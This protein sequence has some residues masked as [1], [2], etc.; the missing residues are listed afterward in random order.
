MEK[1]KSVPAEIEQ[2]V[3]RLTIEL[4]K[5]NAMPITGKAGA[6]KSC[7][8]RLLSDGL[9]PGLYKSFYLC[10]SSVGIVEF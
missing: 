9:P 10:H 1:S 4:F 2:E 5:M 3:F 7:L 8:L 6:G